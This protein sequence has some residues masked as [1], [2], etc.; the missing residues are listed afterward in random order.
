M[1]Q[2]AAIVAPHPPFPLPEA[3]VLTHSTTTLLLL[4]NRT[5]CTVQTYSSAVIPISTE[6]VCI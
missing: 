6:A 4:F 2:L 1:R 5:Y 3:S